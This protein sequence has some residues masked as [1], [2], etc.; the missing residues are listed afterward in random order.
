M[1]QQDKAQALAHYSAQA[2]QATF[3]HKPR[4]SWERYST[5]SY[6][7]GCATI[8]NGEHARVRLSWVEQ[9]ATLGMTMTPNHARALAA[10]LI[11]AADAAE[12]TQ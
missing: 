5:T 6:S 3:E 8:V 4:M 7:D 9:R 1:E 2:S 12:V 11:A 10:E